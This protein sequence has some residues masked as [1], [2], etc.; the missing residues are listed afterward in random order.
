MITDKTTRLDSNLFA[1]TEEI[2]GKKKEL[3]GIAIPILKAIAGAEKNRTEAITVS[4]TTASLSRPIFH[5]LWSSAIDK[6]LQFIVTHIL[7]I[8]S[9]KVRA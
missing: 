2:E 4:R 3:E 5:L 9:W 7:F 1:E 8:P 6:T